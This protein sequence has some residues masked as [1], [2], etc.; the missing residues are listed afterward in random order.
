MLSISNIPCSSV[1]A[2]APEPTTRI[3]APMDGPP[4]LFQRHRAAY[5]AGLLREDGSR[6]EGG[7]RK[8]RRETC[9][10]QSVHRFDSPSRIPQLLMSLCL[11]PLCE[12]PR[13]Q[14]DPAD[15]VRRQG[16]LTAP[17]DGRPSTPGR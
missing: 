11:L 3:T 16:L 13:V 9:R 12:R 8:D 7:H 4:V 15:R 5:G 14:G 1:S 2:N 10:N 6:P 17:A